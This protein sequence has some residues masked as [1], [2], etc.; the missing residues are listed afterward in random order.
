MSNLSQRKS[1]SIE[2]AAA[3]IH[4]IANVLGQV[5]GNDIPA[6]RDPV[7]R[8]A[9]IYAVEELASSIEGNAEDLTRHFQTSN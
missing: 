7:T 8:G 5:D 9:L 1:E 6:I 2:R 3:G 4:G